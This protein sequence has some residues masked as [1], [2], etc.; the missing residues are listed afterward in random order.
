MKYKYPL[1]IKDKFWTLLSSFQAFDIASSSCG[2][3]TESYC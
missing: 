3:Q 1:H 2:Y